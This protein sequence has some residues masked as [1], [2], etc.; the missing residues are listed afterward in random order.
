MGGHIH[1]RP[2][3]LTGLGPPCRTQI[4]VPRFRRLWPCRPSQP[5]KGLHKSMGSVRIRRVASPDFTGYDDDTEPTLDVQC[6][7]FVALKIGRAVRDQ[8]HGNIRFPEDGKGTG[9][10]FIQAESLSDNMRVNAHSRLDSHLGSA[11]AALQRSVPRLPGYRNT[12]CLAQHPVLLYFCS[13]TKMVPRSAE[14]ATT[15]TVGSARP[16]K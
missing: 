9:H 13:I 14:L 4:P 10:I 5:S 8:G 7:Q 3:D 11:S 1:Q 15:S 12:V 2:A 16:G 6:L